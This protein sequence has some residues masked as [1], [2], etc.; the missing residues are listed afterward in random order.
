MHVILQDVPHSYTA[1]CLTGFELELRKYGCHHYQSSEEKAVAVCR[2]A[3]GR[4][5]LWEEQNKGRNLWKCWDMEGVEVR[6]RDSS[7]R[8]AS[9]Q[10]HFAALFSGGNHW[11]CI[12]GG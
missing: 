2:R 6:E 11:R 8:G 3:Q 4:K 9:E 7:K 1:A 10:G 12:R 5:A